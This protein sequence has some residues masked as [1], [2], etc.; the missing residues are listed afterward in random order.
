MKYKSKYKNE[1]LTIVGNNV[2][3]L[4]GK[5]ES[6]K[7]MIALLKPAA[8][9]LQETKL[10]RPG[11]IKIEGFEIFE[12]LCNQGEGGGLMT[13]V[14]KN[15]NPILCCKD[16]DM[17]NILVVDIKVKNTM[18]RLMNCYGPQENAQSEVKDCKL[19]FNLLS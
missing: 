10:Y 13:A 14:H 15:L 9:M 4:L 17:K 2:N 1:S 18:I 6:M 19:K 12:L 7:N 16:E 5:H 3:G 11:K 8:L